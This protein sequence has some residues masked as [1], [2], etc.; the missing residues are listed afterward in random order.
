[1]SNFFTPEHVAKGTIW[2]ILLIIVGWLCSMC[3][4][5]FLVPNVMG[6]REIDTVTAIGLRGL[7]TLMFGKLRVVDKDA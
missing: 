4:N 6:I 7:S 5:M 2:V 3:W 1:M